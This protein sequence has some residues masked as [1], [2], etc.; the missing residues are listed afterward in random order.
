MYFLF[1]NKISYDEKIYLSKKFKKEIYIKLFY[2]IFIYS[3]CI[4]G[5]FYMK[6]KGETKLIFLLISSIL[7]FSLPVF[8]H[9]QS[10][11]LAP[12]LLYLS[13]FFGIGAY[14]VFKKLNFKKNAQKYN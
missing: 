13:I 4:I 10:S 2:S 14:Q 6:K 12:I 8:W 5:L 7:Y 1:E 11:Y 3:I 9:K